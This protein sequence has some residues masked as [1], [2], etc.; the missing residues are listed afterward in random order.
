MK[1]PLLWVSVWLAGVLSV[2]LAGAAQDCRSLEPVPWRAVVPGIWV[3]LPPDRG[4]VSA[5]N[6]GHVMP[7]SVLISGREALVIDPGPSHV[8]GERLRRSLACR[9]GARVRTIVNTHAHSENVL[10]NSAFAD[11]VEAGRTE[12]VAS[13][14]T[15]E[16]MAQRCPDCLA[17]LTLRLGEAAMAGTRIVLPTRTLSVGDE[18]R[19]GRWR[20][21]VA[22]VEHGHTEGDLVLWHAG[23]RIAWAGG[24]VYDGRVPELA[25]GQLDGWLAALDRLEVLRPQHLISTVW[26]RA[27]S[28]EAPPPALAATRAYLGALRQQTLRA[29]DKG[30]QPQETDKVDLPAFHDWSGYQARHGFNVLRAWRELEPVW[31]EQPAPSA[32]D[33]GR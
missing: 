31:M 33:V 14:P 5:S 28:R 8:H 24:L 18:L 11:E 7:T 17:S 16:G 12:I 27:P 10:A 15:R 23:H 25:Q 21:R 19:L 22:R 4:D 32:E 29:M 30:A 2:P 1:Q 13:G 3:W 6:A 26:S 9:F 20:L